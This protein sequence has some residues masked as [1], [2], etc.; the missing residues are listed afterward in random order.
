MPSTATTLQA[1]E[2]A[3]GKCRDLFLAKTLD[4][5][6]SWRVYR[7][8][9]IVDQIFIK[10]RRI[11][12]LQET[13]INR[14]GESITGEFM[15]ILNYAVIG[16]LQLQQTDERVDDLPYDEVEAGYNEAVAQAQQL[17]EKKNHDYGEAWRDMSQ[18]SFADL[19]LAKLLRIRQILRNE[20]KTTVSEG[21]EAN[22][23]D[24]FNYAAFALI[25]I[26]AGKHTG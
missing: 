20:G 4:Y 16:L 15:G 24:I 8:I 12:T 26:Q 23:L 21:I 13:G 7:T 22:Y 9:S 1:Y 18:E 25:L 11:R 3:V 19:I 2:E 5:G 14:V 10:A 6:T 17:M